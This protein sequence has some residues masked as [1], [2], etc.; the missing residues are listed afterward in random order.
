MS[1]HI[2]PGQDDLSL[3]LGAGG[4]KTVTVPVTGTHVKIL[5]EDPQQGV[6]YT[7]NPAPTFPADW[8]KIDPEEEL[9]VPTG[10]STDLYLRKKTFI[11]GFNATHDVPVRVQVGETNQAI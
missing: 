8:D 7:L 10:G 5:N 11:R 3:A 6:L 4:D 9:M 1:V 2:I